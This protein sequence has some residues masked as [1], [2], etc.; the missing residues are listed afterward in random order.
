MSHHGP[1]RKSDTPF[2]AEAAMKFRTPAYVGLTLFALAGALYGTHARGI[3]EADVGELGGGRSD[4]DH[5]PGR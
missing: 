2:G 3:A 1:F 4:Q 5:V